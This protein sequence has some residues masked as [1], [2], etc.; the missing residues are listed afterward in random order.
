MVLINEDLRRLFRRNSLLDVVGEDL[1]ESKVRSD[2]YV[3]GSSEAILF[4]LG[5][6]TSGFVFGLFWAWKNK[7][8]A[9]TS[10]I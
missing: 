7:I 2:V 4:T 5:F 10:G 8:M 9:R 3:G 1:S 6:L